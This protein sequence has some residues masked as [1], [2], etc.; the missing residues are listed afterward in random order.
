MRPSFAKFLVAG[1]AA[2]ALAFGATLSSAAPSVISSGAV[3][4]AIPET[5]GSS[6]ENEISNVDLGA[7][8]E[9]ARITDVNL[10]VRIDHTADQ[11]LDISLI[12]DGVTV[13][14]SRDNGGDGNDYGTGAGCDGTL[15]EF[16]DSA[17]TATSDGAAPFGGSFRPDSSL[18]AFDGKL[19][20]G[21]W[22]LKIV[23]DSDN[24]EVGT[25]VCWKLE[26][27]V[28]VADLEVTVT[29][30]PDPTALGN[31]ISYHASVK[32]LG[33]DQAA[34]TKLTVKLPTGAELASDSPD[35]C[36]DVS[37][38]QVVCDVGDLDNGASSAIDLVVMP[39]TT[40][41]ASAFFSAASDATDTATANSNLVQVDTEVK[42]D[43]SGG[44][45]MIT[46]ETLGL[47]RG[48]VAS[49]PA[50]INC[51]LDCEGG[52]LKGTKVTLT[53]TPETGSTLAAWGGACDGTPADQA[54]E[55]T[56]D[57]AM[58]VTA[59]FDKTS[60][61]GGNG[62]GGDG[63]GGDGGGVY[64]VCTVTGTAGKDILRGT[65]GKDV[66]C[67]LGGADK[68]YGLGGADRIYGGTGKDLVYGGKGNDTLFTTDK[69]ADK[70]Y[71][72]KG[73]DKARGDS[74]DTMNGVE[75]FF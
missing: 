45:E 55:V 59:R 52:F 5:A 30:T 28:A 48:R 46:V 9:N 33:P 6:L 62:G 12:H 67:G 44:T 66:I 7:G 56:A 74:R 69:F 72:G 63:G 31:A 40:G 1:L 54:C 8:F 19:A 51:G 16:D 2:G 22:N 75:R 43:G 23:D 24:L 38:G 27:T 39:T 70:L 13:L 42:A 60:G 35:V 14:V 58:T 20:E 53:A 68:L 41:T 57:G 34:A 61:G 17:T 10:H 11:D 29:D 3:N 65:P 71:G 15:T 18:G 32:N 50:G 64:D 25:L 49:D 47:G 26:I 4:L 36:G 21:D 73:T 37:G